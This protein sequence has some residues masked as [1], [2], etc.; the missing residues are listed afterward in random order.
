MRTYER[1]IQIEFIGRGKILL[2]TL[3]GR[4]EGMAENQLLM[5]YSRQDALDTA[6]FC[7]N[8]GEVYDATIIVE[9]EDVS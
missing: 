3:G 2:K 4:A 5:R 9:M 8:K 1:K 6:L 7:G